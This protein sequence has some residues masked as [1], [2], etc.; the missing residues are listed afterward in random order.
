MQRVVQHAPLLQ[1]ADERGCGLIGL[2]AL[3]PQL[4]GQIVVLV[5]A[6]MEQLHEPHAPFGQPA[7]N[8]AIEGVAALLG[9]VRP[10]TVQHVLGL[11]RPG[12]PAPGRTICMRNA[13]S[14]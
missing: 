14:Y 13:I 8:Q 2:A 10:V 7:G 4:L 1:V 6:L 12:R 9:D 11:T 5:P 3:D